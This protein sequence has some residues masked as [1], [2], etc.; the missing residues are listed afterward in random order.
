MKASH[1]RATSRASPPARPVPRP[2]DRGAAFGSDPPATRR[3]LVADDLL[4]DLHRDVRLKWIAF[5]LAAAVHLM[6]LSINFPELRSP[7]EPQR[8]HRVI[9]VKKYVPPPPQVRRRAVA[10]RQITRKIPIPDPT[11]E[12]PEPIREPEP[13]V[14]PEPLPID[15]EIILG[16]PEPPPAAPAV[17]AEPLLAG[18]GG[19]TQP[20][21]IEMTKI[22]P[23]YPEL[24]RAARLDGDV[25]LRAVIHADGTVG[26]LDVLR[27]TRPGLGFEAAAIEAVAQWRYK[28]ATQNGRPVD[29]YFTVRVEFTLV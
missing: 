21:L 29:V 19:V 12:E 15:A 17:V 28:P 4:V 18:V 16:V 25:I 9:V 24:A 3:D 22:K 20:Q 14:Y 8:D 5:G 10:Q 11:P 7:L 6:L 1:A 27:C 23:E 2:V 13:E 26:E